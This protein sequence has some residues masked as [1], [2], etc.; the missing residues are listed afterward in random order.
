[1][2]ISLFKIKRWIKMLSGRSIDHVNQD[3][4]KCFSPT[5]IHGYYNNL[6]EKVTKNPAILDSDDLPMAY[7]ENQTPIYFPVA[8]FQ[9]GLGAYDLYL[10]T[11]DDKY[12]TKFL[13]CVN[14]SVNNID[15]QG[16][17]NNFFFYT[18][19]TPYGAMAQG[20]GA[21][22]LIRA[23]KHTGDEKYLEKAKEAIDFMLLPLEEG[24]TT[25]YD[26]KDAYL[27]EYTFKGMVMNGAIFAWWG[28]YD[29]VLATNDSGNYRNALDKTLDSLVTVLPKFKCSYWSMYSLDGLIASPFYHNLHVAQME[30]MYELTKISIFKEYAIQWKRQQSN[31]KCKIQ[32]FIRKAFQKIAE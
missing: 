7:P 2:A 11:K 12:L 18:P 23:Y 8:I 3:K 6:T 1:M 30:A 22:L 14:W 10:Q 20:E 19:D 24:G 5:E 9:Y 25:K 16:R 13:Q 31:F 29:Y 15:D 26:G 17:W 32:A 21:S 28:L 4:G 27:M